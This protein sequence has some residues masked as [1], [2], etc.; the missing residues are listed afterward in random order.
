MTTKEFLISERCSTKKYGKRC[1]DIVFS[2]LVLMIGF[3]FFLFLFLWI[4]WDSKGPA[5]YKG[6]RM[7]Q[8]GRLIYCWKFRTMVVEAEDRKSVV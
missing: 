3:P 1:F 4:K 6:L 2:L 8:H 5:F 7:G